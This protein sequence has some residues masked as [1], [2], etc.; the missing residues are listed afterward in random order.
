MRRLDCL[1]GRQKKRVGEFWGK[2][3]E[4]FRKVLYSES[5]PSKYRTLLEIPQQL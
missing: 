3:Y 2:L 4:L 5:Q 1:L